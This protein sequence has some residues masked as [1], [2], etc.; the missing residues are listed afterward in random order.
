MK[1]QHKLFLLTLF[2]VLYLV[3]LFT[4]ALTVEITATVPGCGDEVIGIGEEC[5]DSDL[6][7]AS[8]SSLGFGGGG[9]LACTSI[10]TFDTSACSSGSSGGGGGGGSV[11]SIPAT[12]V[13]F[14]GKAYPRS[15]VVLLKDAQVVATTIAGTDA[16][17]QMTISNVSG[18]NYIFSVYSEDSKGIRSSLLTFPI[19]VTSGVTTKVSGIFIAPTIATDKSEVKRGDNIAIFG[20]SAPF[21]EITV[22]INSEEEYFVKKTTD[23]SGIYLVNFDTSPLEVG[24]HNTKAKSELAGEITSFGKVIGFTV[25]TRN[26]ALL[27]SQALGK[28]D[29]NG[30]NKINLIDFS[31]TAF[32]YKRSNPP[33]SVDL[34]ADGKIDLVD[35]SIL[36]FYW[37][38]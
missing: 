31:I 8:C 4:H 33:A 36:A 29:L 30:D 32:W 16:V 11:P 38:G 19:S 37:T 7:G 24:Q 15:T 23:T 17:F 26:V 10:C 35:F 2:S 1:H 12:N 5:D 3:P 34:N 21:S 13:V 20:Q 18:G 14:T 22:S 25:G 6:G 28:G 9:T 27:L